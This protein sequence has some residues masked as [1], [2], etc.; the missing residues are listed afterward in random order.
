MKMA[1]IVYNEAIDEEIMSALESCCI[2][3]FTK[4]QRVLGR[5]KSSGAHF[6]SG[7]WPGANNVCMAV[8]EDGKVAAILTQIKSLRKTLGKEGIKAFVLPVENLT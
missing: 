6:D 1:V 2:N 5:G 4:W 8:I 7:V 3:S